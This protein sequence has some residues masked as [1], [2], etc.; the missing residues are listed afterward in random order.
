MINKKL[1]MDELKSAG[2][3]QKSMAEIIGISKNSFCSKVNGTSEFTADEIVR[4]CKALEIEDSSK[5]VAIFLK[6]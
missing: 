2:H 5:I 1:F 6:G 4:L 3:T